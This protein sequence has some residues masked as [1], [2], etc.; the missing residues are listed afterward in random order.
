MRIRPIIW[1]MIACFASAC[2]K[3]MPAVESVSRADAV[4]FA[5]SVLRPVTK[6]HEYSGDVYDRG[7]FG[8][9]AFPLNAA[10]TDYSTSASFMNNESIGLSSGAWQPSQDFFWPKRTR[11]AFFGYSPYYQPPA[12][13]ASRRTASY[14]A[15]NNTFTMTLGG[16]QFDGVTDPAQGGVYAGVRDLQYS[17]LALNFNTYMDGVNNMVSNGVDSPDYTGVPVLFHHALCKVNFKARLTKTTDDDLVGVGKEQELP[18]TY[19]HETRAENT[20][21]T[22]D[23]ST[24]ENPNPVVTE[25]WVTAIVGGVEKN[26]KK[27][28]TMTRSTKVEDVTRDVISAKISGTRTWSG[29]VTEF[30]VQRLYRK[31]NLTLVSPDMS[32]YFESNNQVVQWDIAHSTWDLVTTDSPLSL[33]STLSL[34]TEAQSLV[35]EKVTIPRQSFNASDQVHIRYSVSFTPQNIERKIRHESWTLTTHYLTTVVQIKD[36][37]DLVDDPRNSEVK[38]VIEEVITDYAPGTPED[39]ALGGGGNT[40][41]YYNLTFPLNGL[42]GLTSWGMGEIITYT[43]SITPVN[44]IQI[45]WDPAVVE[46]W[47]AASETTTIQP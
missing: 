2:V 16:V 21:E 39:Y 4:S 17:D 10:R 3:E 40:T 38:E 19:S 33:G 6:A 46:E 8:M 45:N 44:G 12:A 25:E 34:T 35:P 9:Y 37:G 20:A 27:I 28:T 41:L 31:G 47:T 36:G 1:L 42:G 14:N 24:V 43:F 30:S 23:V 29:E 5:P 11:L 13:Y 18:N 32:A 22:D 7:P 26:V 15:S